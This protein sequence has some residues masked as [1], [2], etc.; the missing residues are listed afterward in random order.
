MCECMGVCMYVCSQQLDLG[1]LTSNTST[2]LTVKHTHTRTTRAHNAHLVFMNCA[3]AGKPCM[4]GFTAS[5]LG[6]R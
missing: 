1:K 4:R 3:N 5:Q 6:C 2:L